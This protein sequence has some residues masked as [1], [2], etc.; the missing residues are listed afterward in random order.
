[1]YRN[2][3]AMKQSNI[4]WLIAKTGAMS[5]TEKPRLMARSLT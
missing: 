3:A 4:G 1:M 2:I 5:A